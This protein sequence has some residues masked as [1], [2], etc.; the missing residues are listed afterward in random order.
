LHQP[1]LLQP[2]TG[3]PSLITTGQEY[4]NYSSA[5]LSAMTGMPFSTANW[6]G[7][8]PDAGWANGANTGSMTVAQRGAGA[9]FSVDVAAGWAFVV[10][11]DVTNQGVYAVWNDATVNVVTPSAPASG[12]RVHRLVLQIQ[13]KL[14]NGTFTGYQAQYVV[15]QDTGSGTPAASSGGTPSVITL[16]LISISAGQA[17]VQN[18]NIADYRRSVAPVVCFKP[19]DLGR[20]ST[21]SLADDPDLQLWGMASSAT[22]AVTGAIFYHG[23]TGA[24]EGDLKFTFRVPG[25]ATGGYTIIHVGTGGNLTAETRNAWTDTVSVQ[26]TGIGN[27]HGMMLNGTLSTGGTAPNN[28]AAFQWAQNASGIATNTTIENGSYLRAVRIA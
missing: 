25:S 2:A 15:L 22:Y 21:T 9:N 3:D 4:R 13:D 20:G 17:S 12:T 28:F 26:T 1:V 8:V 19:A 27:S 16:A 6:T 23:G 7:G 5:V 11:A 10:G 18:A 24:S 14:E